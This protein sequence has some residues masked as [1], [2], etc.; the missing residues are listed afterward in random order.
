MYEL[1]PKRA[2]ATARMAACVLLFSSLL[3][4]CAKDQVQ[5]GGNGREESYKI[6][7]TV[8]PEGQRRAFTRS[9][10]G[11]AR[12]I[13]VNGFLW[14]AALDSTAFMPLR[15]AD[16][17]GGAIITDWYSPPESPS[18]RFKITVLVQG[19]TLRADGVKVTVFKQKR[20][21]KG[22]WID[23]RVAKNTSIDLENVILARARILREQAA[24]R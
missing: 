17:Y 7:S 6:K 21:A 2:G 16:A 4:G 22:G 12:Q 13:A 3:A 15:S 1:I 9:G 8:A 14:R 11:Q 23:A 19:A 24:A 5:I 20:D 18:E 10:A